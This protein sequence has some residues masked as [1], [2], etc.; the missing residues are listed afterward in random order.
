MHTKKNLGTLAAAFLCGLLVTLGAVAPARAQ[1][2]TT[3]SMRGVVKDKAGAPLAGVTVVATSPALQG[4]QAELT[5][6]SGSYTLTNLPPG[7]YLVTF[8][9]SEIVLERKG[10]DVGLNRT[11]T[12]NQVLDTGA[13]GGETITIEQKV[14]SIDTTSTK[15]SIVVDKDY[16]KNV[17]RNVMVYEFLNRSGGAP[18]RLRPDARP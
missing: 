10:V 16:I 2:G 18:N 1:L 11:S 3:G 6:D 14:G 9:Y 8:Y 13:T 12:V 4:T 5:D 17:W 7:I 15:Q